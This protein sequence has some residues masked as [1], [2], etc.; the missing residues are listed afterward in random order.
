MSPKGREMSKV[1]LEER[2]GSFGGTEK[3]EYRAQ[4]CQRSLLNEIKIVT[5]AGAVE[6]K[7]KL[8]EGKMKGM[9]GQRT[10]GFKEYRMCASATGTPKRL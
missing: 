10:Q 3:K 9:R 8:Q 1:E 5:E 2:G 6:K 4:R 7:R